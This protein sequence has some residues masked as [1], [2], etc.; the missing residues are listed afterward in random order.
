MAALCGGA[1]LCQEPRPQVTEGMAGVEQEREEASRYTRPDP[2]QVYKD[3]GWLSWGDFLGFDEGNV[4][5]EWRPFE[6]ARDYVRSLG[7]SSQKKWEEWRKSGERPPDIPCNP[8]QVYKEKGWLSWGDFLGY[9]PGHIAEKRSTTKK[10]PFAEARDYVRSF[11]LKSQKEWR[12]WRKSGQRPP[13]IPSHPERVYKGKGWLSLGD[14]LGYRPGYEAG[15]RRSFEEARAFVGVLG[16]NSTKEWEEWRKSEEK[17]PDIPS[18]PDRDYKEEGWLSWGDFLGFNEGNVARE[19]R[20]FEEA[21]D[22]ARSLGFGSKKEWHEWSKSGERPSDIPSS[23]DQVYK[24]KG[25]MG[26]GDFLGCDGGH[27]V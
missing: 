25:W 13:N 11:R 21:R 17:P 24:G 26:Y 20:P 3:K 14:F 16:L 27:P 15:E 1:E 2:D 23:P 10:L 12:E 7:L 22:Y 9:K 4:V 5:G 8:D 19:W 6:E 18:N